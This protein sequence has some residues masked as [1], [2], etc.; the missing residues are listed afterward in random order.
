MQLSYLKKNRYLYFMLIPVLLWYLIFMYVPM[1]GLILAFQ[2]YNFSAGYFGSEFVGMEN[3]KILLNDPS[4]RNAFVNTLVINFYRIVFGFPLP[5]IFALLLNEVYH[6]KIKK[7]IQTVTYLPHFISWIVLAGILNSLLAVDSGIVNLLL[8]KLGLSQ[9][10][11]FLENDVFRPMV[12]I[13]EIWKEIGWNTIIYLAAIAG[14]NPA[15]Y[16]AAIVD[17][18]NRFQR[19]LHVTVPCIR[20]VIAI[21]LILQIGNILQMGFDQIYNLYN[22]AVFES[23]DIIDTYIV[24]N[25]TNS[26]NLSIPAAAGLIKSF[27]CF[28]LLVIA[29]YTA[30]RMGNQGIY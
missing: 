4:F 20:N 23:S 22:P 14:I 27:I 1:Y 25:L 11:F 29:N 6:M 7:I 3:L 13:T 30:K 28:G 26:S 8:E 12:I 5:V 19:I 18:A 24:R 9:I 2:D 17:G 21:M 10:N 16:E 15:L